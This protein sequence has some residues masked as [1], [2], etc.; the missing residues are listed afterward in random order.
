MTFG[1]HAIRH[2]WLDTSGSKRKLTSTGEDDWGDD[3]LG[4]SSG[5]SLRKRRRSQ[6]LQHSFAHLT[7]NEIPQR[8]SPSLQ[9]SS[10]ARDPHG[11]SNVPPD[12]PSQTRSTFANGV[13]ASSIEGLPS[14][15][16]DV[17]MDSE[18]G[19]KLI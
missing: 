14:P 2:P 13:T 5:I 10:Y 7:L 11:K 6:V 4:V 18:I 12:R 19:R 3:Y 15:D 17:I 9:T 1:I 8:S 16:I